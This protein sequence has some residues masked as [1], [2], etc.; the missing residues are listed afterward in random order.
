M[1]AAG[2][3][4]PRSGPP[5][6]VAIIGCG[7]VGATL[8]NLL[9]QLGLRVAVL[10]RETSVHHNPRAG[11]LDAE[12]MRVLQAIGLAGEVAA[13]ARVAPGMRFVN[14]QGQLLL[15]WRRTGET[16]E[17]W[18]Q[19]WRFHQP[20]LETILRRGVARFPRVETLLGV[21]V[22]GIEAPDDEPV[23]VACRAL[24]TGVAHR[25]AARY[26]VGCDGG[27][28]ITRRAIGSGLVDLGSRERWMVLDILLREDP[29]DD[30]L[31]DS[32]QHCDPA[33][34]AT[35]IPM[36]GRRRRWEFM[37]MPGDDPA[38][39]VEPARVWRLLRPWGVGPDTAGIE[40]AVVYTFHANLARSW[41][42]GRVLLAGDAAHQMPPFL[43]QGLCA[44][45][46][47][48]ANLAWKLAVAVRDAAPDT[49]LDSYQS[50]RA[51][52][53]QAVIA[54]AVRLG[55]L[56]QT[57]DL[58]EAAARD[59]RMVDA[60][61]TLRVVMPALGPGLGLGTRAA[62]PVMADGQRLDDRVGYRFAV[63]GLPETLAGV[64]PDTAAIWRRADARVVA[65][66]GAAPEWLARL[67]CTAVII[68]PDRAVLATASDAGGLHM[69]SR[70]IPLPA[71][72]PAGIAA[73]ATMLASP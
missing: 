55:G 19:A 66:D 15:H 29:A 4:I 8:A 16:D 63:L 68:R 12:G 7:P 32:V 38:T 35:Y 73:R 40:R 71:E 28:S 26:V 69:I 2:L 1:A 49:L 10:E 70:L 50:E 37:L 57:V 64:R 67:G 14:A 39:M 42:R 9:G 20:T 36:V 5:F 34:P 47:D 48:V 13:T 53:V 46:R 17:G 3:T 33:R 23:T 11:S 60:P 30:A 18:H 56:I 62:Q 61:E 72:A 41:R 31:G 22:T 43:G 45:L 52:H 65:A 58:A 25:I 44:G 21:E 27:R 6:D 24:D 51:P 54:L 59:R